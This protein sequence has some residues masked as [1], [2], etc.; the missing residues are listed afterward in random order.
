MYPKRRK[1]YITNNIAHSVS[2]E[3][4]AFLKDD[5]DELQQAKCSIGEWSDRKMSYKNLQYEQKAL[6]CCSNWTL[7]SKYWL[8]L[9]LTGQLGMKALL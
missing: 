3:L 9:N 2:R 4:Q 7:W 8:C 1:I 6:E 5:N